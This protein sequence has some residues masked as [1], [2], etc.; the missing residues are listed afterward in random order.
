MRI[1]VIWEGKTRD[2]H[3]RAL[4]A[5]YRERISHFCNIE[6]DEI[7]PVRAPGRSAHGKLSAGERHLLE[8]LKGSTRVF[9]DERGREWNSQEFAQ[10]LGQQA[11]RGTR[12]VTFLVG[13]PDGFTAPFRE[14][15]D[16]LM[17]LSRMTLTHDWIRALLL[18]QIYRGFT[19]LRGYP[20]AH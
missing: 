13:G 2:A 18:E 16:Q 20:Y 4:A 6:I 15:A 10:W 8:K 3:L 14:E 12:E 9:L 5:D 1:R 11:L 7:Q 17:A 19:I